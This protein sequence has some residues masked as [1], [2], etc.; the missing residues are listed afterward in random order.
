M[1]FVGDCVW[2]RLAGFKKVPGIVE[3]IS[4]NLGR[5][6]AQLLQIKYLRGDNWYHISEDL[7]VMPNA[8]YMELVLER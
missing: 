5:N 3:S 7:E 8:E 2:V 6:S 1:F 4:S